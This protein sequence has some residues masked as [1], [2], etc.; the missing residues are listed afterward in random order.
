MYAR[1]FAQSECIGRHISNTQMLKK[2]A[3]K[4]SL[5]TENSD[6]T[7]KFSLIFAENNKN[8]TRSSN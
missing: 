7:K 6:D 1:C 2:R 5:F 4:Y 3:I 8:A